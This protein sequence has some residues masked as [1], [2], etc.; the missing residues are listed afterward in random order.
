MR[1]PRRSLP[2][3]PIGRRRFL[4]DAGMGFTG[5]VLGTM[6]FEDGIARGLPPE[7]TGA[8]PVPK[9]KS[10]IWLFMLGGASHLE[11]FDPKPALHKYAGKTIAE[12]PCAKHVLEAPQLAKNFRKFAGEARLATT[13]L[14]PQVGFRPY[15]QSGT[16]VCDWLPHLGGC[17]D[18]LAVIR[19]LWTTDFNH[20]AQMLF[21]TGRLIL[22]GREPCLGSWVH[23]GLGTLN[24]RL[25]RFVVLGRP[26]SDF[27]GGYASHQ[28]SYL[29][30]EHD[31]VPVEVDPQRAVPYPPLGPAQ[32]HEAQQ[33]EFEL[34]GRLNRLAA[35]E[36]PSDPALQARIKAYELAFR[37]QA[38]FPE[39][40]N[41]QSESKETRLLYGLDD[42]VTRP[43]GRQCL[44]A[45]RLVEQGVRFIQ[46]YHGGAADDDNGL[47]DSHQELQKNTRQRCAE[48][49][50]PI[51]GLLKDLKRRGLLESTLVVWATEFGR[52][53][54]VEPLRANPH[55]SDERLG[56]DHHIYGFS[57]WLAGGG[58]KG[59]VVHG[60]TDELGFH[61]VEQRHYVTDIHATVLHLLGL[62]PRRL[63][64]PGHKRLDLERGRPMTEIL[65]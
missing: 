1:P 7:V 40:V 62:D 64:I 60:R 12:T 57:A 4:A 39:I 11:T 47:W 25:P 61:A 20:T 17:V 43:F 15:G 29:G 34:V 38:S 46:I 22:D 31:G 55:A 49:D 42:P 63:E 24:D 14:A 44:V 56:R 21:H 54:N 6:L 35:V 23:Y 10:V 27:G 2:G 28:A 8:A 37:M 33:A 58:I 32:S 59:G 19:S 9:A 48:V 45:R 16:E 3:R 52:T 13:L 50:R 30:P 53:P 18:D 41:L 65:A 5:L 51:S 36:Y 26:P